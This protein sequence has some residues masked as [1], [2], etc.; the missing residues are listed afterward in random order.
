MAVD[1]GSP[2]MCSMPM[3]VID[4]DFSRS[5]CVNAAPQVGHFLATGAGGFDRLGI[6]KS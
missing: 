6:E 4:G 1:A 2:S 3:G 5:R